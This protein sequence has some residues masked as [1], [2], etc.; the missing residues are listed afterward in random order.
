MFQFQATL[1]NEENTETQ[2]TRDS[3]AS[4]WSI[5]D[6]GNRTQQVFINPNVFYRW[7]TMN[8]FFCQFRLV[9]FSSKLVSIIIQQDGIM[10]SLFISATALHVSD[11]IS[12]HH[13]ELI[14]LYLQYL[15]LMRPLQLP[16]VRVTLKTGS[17]L[18]CCSTPDSHPY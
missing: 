8:R 18:L 4:K 11:G 6:F 9:K 5:I 10:Y 3:F 12:T 17:C 14:S 15:A 7:Q 1:K 13:Q 2:K 16:V